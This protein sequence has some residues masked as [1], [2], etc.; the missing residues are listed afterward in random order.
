MKKV[1]VSWIGTQDRRAA[2][3]QATELG[4]LAGAL[5]SFRKERDTS[6]EVH[7]L[8]ND[9]KED[10]ADFLRWIASRTAGVVEPWWSPLDSPMDLPGIYTAAREWP[11]RRSRNDTA[12]TSSLS[13]TVVQALPLWPRPGFA[14]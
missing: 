2:E 12:T 11:A 6:S 14:E 10:V 13:A 3:D 5:E 9:A 4:P 1:L 7:L 8:H